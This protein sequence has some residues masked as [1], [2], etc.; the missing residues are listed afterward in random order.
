MA[1][2][3]FAGGHVSSFHLT[4]LARH[5]VRRLLRR[6]L[7]GEVICRHRGMNGSDYQIRAEPIIGQPNLII[8]IDRRRRPGTGSRLPT[9][10]QSY[11]QRSA[12]RKSRASSTARCTSPDRSIGSAI[13]RQHRRHPHRSGRG[14]ECRRQIADHLY[15]VERHRRG[16]IG[17]WRVLHLSREQPTFRTA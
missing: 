9:S 11:K 16:Q 4:A 5:S 2:T 10:T 7:E 13:S 3:M 17:E 6:W 15:R 12:G 1:G 8:R 14:P